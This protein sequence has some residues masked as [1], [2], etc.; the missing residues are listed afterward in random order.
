MHPPNR[1]QGCITA[2]LSAEAGGGRQGQGQYQPFPEPY[3]F[4]TILPTS[5]GND[6]RCHVA[7]VSCGAPGHLHSVKHSWGV[8]FLATGTP[9]RLLVTTLSRRVPPCSQRRSPPCPDVNCVSSKVQEGGRGGGPLK[10]QQR[11]MPTDRVRGMHATHKG[12][13]NLMQRPLT[14][15][16]V[17]P[18]YSLL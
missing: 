7:D 6:C 18:C 15:P 12:A 9:F 3:R 4:A 14:P 1:H 2:S 17:Q 10:Q 16:L 8:T 5:R 11:H 13:Y